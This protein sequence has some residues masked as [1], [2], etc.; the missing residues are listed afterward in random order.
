VI[1]EVFEAGLGYRKAIYRP[2][3]QAVPKYPVIDTENCIFFQ[4]GKCKACQMFCPTEAMDFEQ[5]DQILKLEVGNIIL[6][7]GYDTFDP[8]R[9][10]QYG[11][12]RLANV[13]TS[14]EFERMVNAAGPTGGRIV[15][16]DGESRPRAWRSSTASARATRTST[17][18]ARASAAC[19]RSSSRTCCTSDCPAPRSTT[20]TLTSAP[21]QALR[22]VLPPHPGRG[23]ALH[24]R[25]RGRGDRRGAHAGRGG[26]ADR[27]G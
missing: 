5:Q 1:D 3:P 23:H 14:L 6:A 4:R 2:F 10:P 25:A 17:S 11:Y 15:L 26:Q 16:R 22:G 21:R 8:R 19:T 27:P 24:P 13:F 12:G 7:T 20:S 18:T 9:I